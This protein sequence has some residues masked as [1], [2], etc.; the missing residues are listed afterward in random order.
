MSEGMDRFMAAHQKRKRSSRYDT[1]NEF[2]IQHD[3]LPDGAFFAIA[4]E[5]G[6][7]IDDWAWFAIEHERRHPN[8]VPR[9]VPDQGGRE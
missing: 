9:A 2:R 6:I 1:I 3:D 8:T 7:T 5:Q 4:E